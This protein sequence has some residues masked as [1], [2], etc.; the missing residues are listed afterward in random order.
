MKV[1]LSSYSPKDSLISSKQSAQMISDFYEDVQPMANE[2]IDIYYVRL[3]N[4][5]DS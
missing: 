5:H 1:I 4:F 2:I 3:R